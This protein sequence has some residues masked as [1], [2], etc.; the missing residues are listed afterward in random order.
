MQSIKL[1]WVFTKPYQ[2]KKI[3][4]SD[5][6]LVCKT[7]L[8]D[9]EQL[10]F[11]RAKSA[12]DSLKPDF[13]YIADRFGPWTLRKQKKTLSDG[14][15]YI[16]DCDGF[17]VECLRRCKDLGVSPHRFRIVAC[18]TENKEKHM[19]STIETE[20]GSIVFDCRANGLTDINTLLLKGYKFRSGSSPKGNW[21]QI[22]NRRE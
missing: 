19:V 8:D 9:D 2:Y 15:I 3:L 4:R 22:L 6:W 10:V 7:P 18:V 11:E 20:E 17:A 1:G 21:H 14:H 12:F 5:K 16:G 13:K